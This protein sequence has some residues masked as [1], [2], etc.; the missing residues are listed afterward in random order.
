MPKFVNT[1]THSAVALEKALRAKLDELLR[2]LDWLSGWTVESAHGE[3]ETG[4]D[5]LVALPLRVT[6]G[7]P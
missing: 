7:L 4:C 1:I 5:L 6:T 2:G 3:L